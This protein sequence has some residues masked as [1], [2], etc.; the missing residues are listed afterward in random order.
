[1]INKNFLRSLFLSTNL[2]YYF[3]CKS[4]AFFASLKFTLKAQNIQSD[5]YSQHYVIKAVSDAKNEKITDTCHIIGSGWSLLQ[6][7]QNISKND[8]VFGFNYSALLNID[9]DAYFFEF[10]GPHALQTSHNHCKL[11]KHLREK[12]PTELIFFKNIWQDK[13]SVSF[14]NQ[15]WLKLAMPIKDRL[16]FMPFKPLLY[17]AL[18]NMITDHSCYLPQAVSTAITLI[19]L[20]YKCNFKHIVLHGIDFGGSYF[21]QL[22][23]FES[24]IPIIPIQE[25]KF[26]L[27]N[28]VSTVHPTA[29][30]SVGMI[31]L[32]PVLFNVLDDLGCTL[33]TASGCS[34]SS[35]ILPQFTFH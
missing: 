29:S 11:A 24:S 20:A 12:T 14:I 7:Y 26:Y 25:K 13:N 1:M 27:N 32:L 28:S 8:F 17:Q 15:H 23:N 30:Y 9:F 33:Y 18:Q 3:L 5:L 34:P 10:G 16:Y 31:D 6:S 22:P 35:R 19:I 4:N 21:Y 2:G